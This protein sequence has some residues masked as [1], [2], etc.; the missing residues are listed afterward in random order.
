[1]DLAA[2]DAAIERHHQTLAGLSRKQWQKSQTYK[3]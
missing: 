3:Q 2:L 1:V